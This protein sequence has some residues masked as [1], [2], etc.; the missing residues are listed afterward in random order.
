MCRTGSAQGMSRAEWV[1]GAVNTVDQSYRMAQVEQS[2][3][4]DCSFGRWLVEREIE[5]RRL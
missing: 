5:V 2:I 3:G 1:L 4:L